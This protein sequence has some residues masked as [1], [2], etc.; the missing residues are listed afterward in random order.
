MDNLQRIA[1]LIDADNTQ[2]GKL[3]AVIREISTH[4]RIVVKKAFGNWRKDSLKNWEEEIKRLAINA[5]QQ[6]DYVSGKNV[7]DIALVIDAMDMLYK[8]LYDAFVIVSSDS[9][10]TPLAIR[11]HES[12]VFVIGVGEKKTPVPFRNACDEFI[13]LENLGE[14][15]QDVEENKKKR[16][17]SK[18]SSRNKKAKSKADK[19]KPD[20]K[21]DLLNPEKVEDEAVESINELH[22]LLRIAYDRYVDDDGFV[23]VASAGT[24]IKRAMPDFDTRTYGYSKL[25]QLVED[26]PEKYE[27]KRKSGKGT[28]TIIVYRCID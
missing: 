11:I 27:V 3:E 23:N 10:Y 21:A 28:T 1:L 12:G 19:I 2:I 13:F 15:S 14:D 8:D 22:S 9:D 25:P 7:S 4:G 16:L 17:A 5:N 18:K 24:Y 20:S 6:F 26:F